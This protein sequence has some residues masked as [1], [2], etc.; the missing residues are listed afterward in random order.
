MLPFFNMI[1]AANAE[2]KMCIAR[3]NETETSFT[4]SRND[5]IAIADNEKNNIIKLEAGPVYV[6]ANAMHPNRKPD[7]IAKPPPIGVGDLWLLR[8]LG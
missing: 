8:A 5:T 2:D 7:S 6:G 4:S 1:Y 3:R